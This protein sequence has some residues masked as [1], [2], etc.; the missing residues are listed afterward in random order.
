MEYWNLDN[1]QGENWK[2][3]Q[4]ISMCLKTNLKIL[5]CL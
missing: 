5:V 4:M 1:Y 3:I 2:I